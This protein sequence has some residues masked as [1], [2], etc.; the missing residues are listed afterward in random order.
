MKYTLKALRQ[1]YE[2]TQKQAAMLI[3]VSE[4]TWLNWEKRKTFPDV[5]FIDRIEKTFNV[6]YNDIIFL[7]PVTVKPLKPKQEV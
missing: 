6:S 5:P 7:T 2:L 1:K 4:S 3:G